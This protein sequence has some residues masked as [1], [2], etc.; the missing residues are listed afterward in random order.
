[1]SQGTETETYYSIR[2]KVEVVS[3]TLTW[4][5]CAKIVAPGPSNAEVAQTLSDTAIGRSGSSDA[6]EDNCEG[7]T[8]EED[9]KREHIKKGV[10]LFTPKKTK[11]EYNLLDVNDKE[12]K[13]RMRRINALGLEPPSYQDDTHQKRWIDSAS[14]HRG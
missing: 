10:E 7:K 2:V 3:A 12:T 4:G 5:N 9:G 13:S 11:L 6:G 14:L 1:M 8:P